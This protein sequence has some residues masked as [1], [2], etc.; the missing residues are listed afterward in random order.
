MEQ[1]IASKNG[2]RR[3]GGKILGQLMTPIVYVK[4]QDFNHDQYKYTGNHIKSDYIKSAEKNKPKENVIVVWKQRSTIQAL[5][6]RR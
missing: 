4:I 1:F 2:R 3:K 6:R 5:S